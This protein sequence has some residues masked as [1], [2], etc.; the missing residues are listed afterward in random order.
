[1]ADKKKQ[2]FDVEYI[3]GHGLRIFF[4]FQFH[5]CFY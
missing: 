4:S 3:R 2:E 1:M 5:P